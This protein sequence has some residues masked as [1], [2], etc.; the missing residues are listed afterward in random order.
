MRERK[1][2]RVRQAIIRATADLTL[3]LGFA[4]ATIARIAERADV[5]PRTVSGRFPVK[6]NILFEDISD[7]VARF[8]VRIRSDEGDIV[9]R[10]EIWLAEESERIEPDAELAKLRFRAILSDPSLRARELQLLEPIRTAVA[11]AVAIELDQ[12]AADMGPQV[13]ASATL[14]FLLNV[15][16]LNLSRG[17]Q[18]HER[19][20][21]FNF[22]RG[23]LDALRLSEDRWERP[24]PS[25]G[26]AC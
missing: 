13:F 11:S 17:P 1:N 26:T 8:E 2:H 9:D 19:E 10:I 5:A 20:A 6:E 22:L 7:Q 12:Q 23:G 14:G 3:E 24:A 21:G 25:E 15:R 4:A 16:T 18:S